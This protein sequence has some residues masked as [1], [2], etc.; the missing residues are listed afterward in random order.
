MF[1]IFKCKNLFIKGSVYAFTF[2]KTE[3]MSYR[4]KE[5][6]ISQSSTIQRTWELIRYLLLP[7]FTLQSQ[8]K[9]LGRSK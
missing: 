4:S 9:Q 7:P 8:L 2:G 5:S 3:P 6:E 1:S